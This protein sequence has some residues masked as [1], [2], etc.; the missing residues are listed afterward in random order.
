MTVIDV[1]VPVGNALLVQYG[2]VATSRL[3]ED[4]ER[5]CDLYAAGRLQKP[6]LALRGGEDG[7]LCAA[8]WANERAA[9]A[10]A[11]LLLPRRGA[12]E[13][14]MLEAIVGLSYGGD[15]RMAVGAE[16]EG[17][18]GAIAEGSREP[19]REMYAPHLAALQEAGLLSLTAD[20]EAEDACGV[21][22]DVSVAAEAALAAQ[23][24][25]SFKR[26]RTAGRAGRHGARV[27]RARS[28]RRRV[29]RRTGQGL[30]VRH[31]QAQE[32]HPQALEGGS[33]R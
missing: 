27:E 26:S 10:A 29:H 22:R 33:D 2:V 30:G 21:E 23:L 5:W 14:E 31:G 19:M 16:A 15:V 11:L 18:V 24:P 3:R 9:L 13:R 8:R 28:G 4:L 6:T 25:P 12:S 20:A 17:K 7:R 32:G 1:F